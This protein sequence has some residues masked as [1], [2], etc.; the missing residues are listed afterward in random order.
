L[1]SGEKQR[2]SAEDNGDPGR[3]GV[4]ERVLNGKLVAD[5]EDNDAGDHDHASMAGGRRQLGRQPSGPSLRTSMT[6]QSR[7]VGD[8]FG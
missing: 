2:G 4:S 5:G 8:T 7:E 6:D 1:L 3:L